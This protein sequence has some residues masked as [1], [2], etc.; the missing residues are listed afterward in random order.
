MR[1][2]LIVG[3]GQSGLHLAHGLLSHGYDVTLITGQT[4]IEI[5]TGRP[6]ITQF[7]LPTVLG[8]E[9]E[10]QLDFWSSV[11]PHMEKFNVH[12][13]PPGSPP[14]VIQGRNDGYIL[15]VDRR[16]KMADW[17]EYF[18]DRG[19]KVVIHGVT[20]SDLDYFSRMF[21]LVVVAVGAGELGALFDRDP[22]RISAARERVLAQ[23]Y[24]DGVASTGDSDDTTGWVATTPAGNVFLVPVLT[25]QGPCHSLFL[26]GEPGGAVDTWHDKPSPQQQLDRMKDHLRQHMPEYYER[27]RNAVLIDGKSRLIERL[28][29][30]VR[31]PVGR[32]PSGGL[33]LGI[34]DVV[35]TTDPFGGQGWNNSTRCAKSYLT[36]IL[37]RGDRPFDEAYL[38]RMFEDFWSYGQSAEMWAQMISTMWDTELPEHL[39]EVMGAAM[40][41]PEV[42]DRWIQGWDYPPDYQNWL[43]DPVLA[44]KYLAEVAATRGR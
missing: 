43:L 19:G 27:C 21:D 34:A 11:A 25:A 2:I 32:L 31:Q 18:E 20:L 26:V 9:R 15:S 12:M 3:A 40:V 30:Q 44:R 1:K 38:R 29:P 6:S 41:Y 33:V 10:L 28:H 14:M 5:R 17:L 7:T 42:A 22:S 39:Q 23:V 13:Y 4:S 8:Y 24:I 16:V 37:D 35:V 36:S